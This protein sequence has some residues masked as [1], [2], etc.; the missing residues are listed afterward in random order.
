MKSFCEIYLGVVGHERVLLL[1]WFLSWKKI[2]SGKSSC[3][4]PLRNIFVFLPLCFI[5]ISICAIIFVFLPHFNSKSSFYFILKI[6]L[7]F[8]HVVFLSCKNES[9][10]NPW[11]HNL[12]MFFHGLSLF[13]PLLSS[14]RF[15]HPLKD[16]IT[17][18]DKRSTSRYCVLVGGNFLSWKSK[19]KNVLARSSVVAK[20]MQWW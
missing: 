14:S 10:W 16:Y 18:S 11:F 5:P 7:V 20:Y 17:P 4:Y 6:V 13:Q 12:S 9:P 15:Y 2:S 8:L 3:N 1:F 19:K